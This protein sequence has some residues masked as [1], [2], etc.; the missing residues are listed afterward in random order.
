MSKNGLG[1]QKKIQIWTFQLCKQ[2]IEWTPLKI[3][4]MVWK[5]KREN[6]PTEPIPKYK[7]M[8]M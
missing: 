5:I 6:N 2:R 3:D 7:E 8:E 1:M 4:L